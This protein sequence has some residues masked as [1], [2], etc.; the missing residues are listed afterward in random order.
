MQLEIWGNNS[1]PV[2]KDATLELVAFDLDSGEFVNKKTSKVTLA[3]N[4]S[5]EFWKGTVPGQPTRTSLGQVPKTIVVGAR[6][7][8]EDGTV[9]ARY[10]E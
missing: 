8:D 6:L 1:A 3:P 4:S 2:A 10:G 9:L 7:I 5:T